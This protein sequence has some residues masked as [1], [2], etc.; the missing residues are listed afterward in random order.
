MW[1][2]GFGMM[3]GLF[4]YTKPVERNFNKTT[5]HYVV[6]LGDMNFRVTMEANKCLRALNQIKQSSKR[7]MAYQQ[8]I[9][10]LVKFDQLT[11]AL[12]N[13][14]SLRNLREKLITFLPTYKLEENA[15]HYSYEKQRTPSW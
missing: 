11:N 1:G 14:R 2:S 8:Q 9:A 5:P 6:A 3:N 12:R 7:G 15:D 4:A 10:E 13:E